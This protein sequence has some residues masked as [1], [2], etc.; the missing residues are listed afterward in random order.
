MIDL[1]PM[2]R[3]SPRKYYS[4]GCLHN[5]RTSNQFLRAFYLRQSGTRCLEERH[6]GFI[7]PPLCIHSLARNFLPLQVSGWLSIAVVV[8][9][10]KTAYPLTLLGTIYWVCLFYF[11]TTSAMFSSKPPS[12]PCILKRKAV[13]GPLFAKFCLPSDSYCSPYH[14]KIIFNLCANDF[15]IIFKDCGLVVT[16]EGFEICRGK[17]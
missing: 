17:L 12:W 10:I 3:L 8:N 9:C 16:Q 11:A 6:S 5:L 14:G 1:A 4:L 13:C 7:D 2:P 15:I